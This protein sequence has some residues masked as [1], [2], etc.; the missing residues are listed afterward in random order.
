MTNNIP[1]IFIERKWMRAAKAW[2]CA[3]ELPDDSVL[4]AALT[5]LIE[6][7][8]IV[9]LI[10]KE[11]MIIIDPA[12]IVDVPSKGKR[13]RLVIETV[14]EQQAAHGPRLT[15]MTGQPVSVTILPEGQQAAPVEKNGQRGTIDA[16]ALKGL[17]V[18]FFKNQKFSAFLSKKTGAHIE[19]NQECKDAFK[20]LMRVESCIEINQ[21][22]FD[23][24]L[25]E[26]NDWLNGA[27]DAG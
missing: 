20:K 18:A 11:V 21:E 19:G 13:F 17:H 1:C 3:I 22:D 2:R 10:T 24:V 15:A 27:N 8:V 16:K 9:H 26:F 7:K 4:A 6:H 23:A 5:S 14:F 25:K 12:F